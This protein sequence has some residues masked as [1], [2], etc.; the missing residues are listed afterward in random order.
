MLL[1]EPTNH[2][3]LP[4]REELER[5]LSFFGGTMLIATHDRYFMEK[6]SD[7]L[8]V[9]ERGTLSKY[10]GGYSE[11]MDRESAAERLDLMQLERERQ[12]VLGKLSFMT[13][14]NKEYEGLDRRF[15]EL[16]ASIKMIGKNNN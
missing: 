8:L 3:D 15:N 9:F 12:E 2:L 6:L 7:K 14:V 5:A 16:T 10:E 4:S 11:W 1:D 13:P